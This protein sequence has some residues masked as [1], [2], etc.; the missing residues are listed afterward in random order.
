MT[1]INFK[2]QLPGTVDGTI[3]QVTDLLKAEGFGILTR[4]DFHL[5]MKEK[6]G[7]D[8]PATVILGACNPNMAFE[9][10][11]ANTDVTSLMPCNVVVRDIGGGRVSVE[12]ARPSALLQPLADKALDAMT[13]RADAQLAAVLERLT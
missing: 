1:T 12:I 2:K 10:Y 8:V 9:A 13:G 11:S 6:L 3:A 4:I 5:K 7:K